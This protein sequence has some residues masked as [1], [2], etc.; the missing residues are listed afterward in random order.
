MMSLWKRAEKCQAIYVYYMLLIDI[1]HLLSGLID[2]AN[3]VL[4]F[5]TL[6]FCTTSI[7]F[8]NT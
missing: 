4:L 5:V 2:A 1:E 8:T 6:L 3:I 7:L